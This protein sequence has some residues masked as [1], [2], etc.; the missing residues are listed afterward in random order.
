M[1]CHLEDEDAL[2]E[3]TFVSGSKEGEERVDEGE[4]CHHKPFFVTCN[5]PNKT[6]HAFGADTG[7]RGR[8]TSIV[9]M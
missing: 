2:D 1:H 6:K 5:N 4:V 9:E 7:R 8:G 3:F